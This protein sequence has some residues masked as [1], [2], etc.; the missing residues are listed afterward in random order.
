MPDEANPLMISPALCEAYMRARE[1]AVA[2]AGM[3]DEESL[4]QSNGCAPAIERVRE[5][6]Q[7]AADVGHD[8][9]GR[10]RAAKNLDGNPLMVN[11]DYC[12][13]YASAMWEAKQ[14]AGML[15]EEHFN[16]EFAT[17]RALRDFGSLEDCAKIIG[18]D[19]M[20]RLRAKFLTNLLS[21]LQERGYRV[22]LN[23]HDAPILYTFPPLPDFEPHNPDKEN[24]R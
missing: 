9:I 3:I 17:Q 20:F 15:R 2:Q 7:A 19:F 21:G 16:P 4:A 14:A 1:A 8:Y 13:H 10:F 12:G 22:W 5:L 24:P 18:H 23:G 11:P 6:E